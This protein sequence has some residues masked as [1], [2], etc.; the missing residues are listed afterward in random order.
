[1]IDAGLFQENE[2]ITPKHA[3]R[4]YLSVGPLDCE[5]GGRLEE[6]N[7]AY[8]TWGTLNQAKSNAI[9]VCHALT[10]DSHAI[11]WWQS[12]VGPHK[13]IDTEKYFVVCSNVL[14]GCQGSTGPASLIP[15]S[16]QT[17]GASFPVITIGDMVKVQRRLIQALG[18]THLHGVAGGSMGGM[19]ALEWTVQAP[20]QVKKAFVTASAASHG[21]MQIGFNE[22]AR[23]AIMRD[24]KWNC[25][26]YS[27]TDPPTSGLAVARMIGHL[28][29]L[30]E[31]AFTHKF[32]RRL[33]GKDRP[34]YRLGL[35]FEVESYLKHQ[36]EKFTTRFDANSL[37]FLTRAIDYLEIQRLERAEA[38]FL[39]VSFDSDWIYPSHLSDHLARIAREAGCIAQHEV[40]SLPFGHDG[41][42]LDGTHQGKL[43]E[44]FFAGP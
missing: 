41:F 11:G 34:D 40:V 16:T 18:I 9:L 32:S 13:P 23:Q 10:G 21:A 31:S 24:P 42:L 14:G 15:G 17:Y 39:F 37:L 1:V 12:L 25:G 6:V 30:S 5:A 38:Q 29:F 27:P 26:N 19:Q 44:D 43:V 4:S 22:A 35:E 7:L 3:Q 36:G 2:R 28:T 8:E 20:S 33:Q